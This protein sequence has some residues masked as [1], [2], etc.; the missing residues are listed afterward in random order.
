MFVPGSKS[1]P[2]RS[3]IA[4]A[5]ASAAHVAH[6][7]LSASASGAPVIQ[8]DPAVRAGERGA[9]QARATGDPRHGLGDLGTG[10]HRVAERPEPA[11]GPDDRDVRHRRRV[12][13]AGDDL[14]ERVPTV[15]PTKRPSCCS[16]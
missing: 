1:S 11:G 10:G 14:R 12:G 3:T 8:P 4:V 9:E 7:W 16:T 15:G 13:C 2:I 5:S 6:A